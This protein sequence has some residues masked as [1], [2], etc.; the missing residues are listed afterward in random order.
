MRISAFGIGF[1]PAS[2]HDSISGQLVGDGLEGVVQQVAD[3][4]DAKAGAGADFLVGQVLIELEPDQLAAAVVE[5]LQAEADQADA[6]PAGD[7]LVGQRLGIG[8][9]VGRAGRRRRRAG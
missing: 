7:L 9:I 8:G 3:V 1:P 2:W 6:F 4:A 5:G